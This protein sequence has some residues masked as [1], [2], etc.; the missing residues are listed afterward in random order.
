[1]DIGTKIRKRRQEIGLSLRELGEKAGITAGFLSQV[2]NNQASPSLNSLHNIA[3]ALNAPM[4]YFLDDHPSG[5]VVKANEREKIIFPGDKIEYE[6]LTSE[7]SRQM[8]TLLIRLEPYTSRIALPLPR[9][10]EQWMYV[11]H[12][13]LL[14][15][16]NNES[17]LLNV[18]DT[19]YFDGDLLQEFSSAS[20]RQLIVLCCIRP[21]I[22]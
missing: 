10:T 5:N 1:M 22:L 14:I 20:G 11:I 8:M 9:P 13:E 19:V 21:P 7:L 16:I 2:E 17:Y 12:G 3:R 6:L 4:F 18:G 15:K